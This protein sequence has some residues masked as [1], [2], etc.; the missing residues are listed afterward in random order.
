MSSLEIHEHKDLTGPCD[1]CQDN[2]PE[3]FA[4]AP[5]DRPLDVVW[6]AGEGHTHLCKSCAQNAMAMLIPWERIETW[7]KINA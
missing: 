2:E 1:W 3:W 5:D 6:R 7:E 4:P